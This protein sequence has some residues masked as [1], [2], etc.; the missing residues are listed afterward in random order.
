MTTRPDDLLSA[1]SVSWE[2]VD[3][4]DVHSALFADGRDFYI[5]FLRSGPDAIYVYP[6][7]V[8]TEWDSFRTADSK[9]SWVHNHPRAEGWPYDRLTTRSFEHIDPTSRRRELREFLSR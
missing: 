4:S 7:R 5:R 3:S 1:R 8:P 2:V 9:G 6:D